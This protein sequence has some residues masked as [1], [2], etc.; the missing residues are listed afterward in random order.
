MVRPSYVLFLGVLLLIYL[1]IHILKEKRIIC[2]SMISECLTLHLV[3]PEIYMANLFLEAFA[4]T[5]VEGYP[6]HPVTVPV[7][8]W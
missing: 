7:I 1:D 5:F 2:V 8:S 4:S 6:P 3:I